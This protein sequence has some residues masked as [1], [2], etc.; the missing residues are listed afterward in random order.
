VGG[1]FPRTGDNI[2][3]QG[4]YPSMPDC[5]LGG[6][7]EKDMRDDYNFVESLPEYEFRRQTEGVRVKDRNKFTASDVEDIEKIEMLLDVCSGVLK[8]EQFYLEKYS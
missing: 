4:A 1:V 8:N 6:A 5:R 7:E 3:W 2:R